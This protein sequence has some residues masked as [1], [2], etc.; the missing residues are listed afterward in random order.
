MQNK[1]AHDHVIITSNVLSF[2]LDESFLCRLRYAI[3]FLRWG[4]LLEFAVKLNMQRVRHWDTFQWKS[5][6][7]LFLSQYI[8]QTNK[9]H[10]DI[11][12]TSQY[13]CYV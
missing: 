2:K 4:L 11:N 6:D 12:W 13:N 5:H 10:Y 7:Q 9:Q 3:K 1:K 8:W